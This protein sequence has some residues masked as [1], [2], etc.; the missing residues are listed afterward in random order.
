M[1]NVN[2]RRVARVALVFALVVLA[3]PTVARADWF[4]TPF[5]GANFGGATSKNDLGA[6]LGDSSALTYGVSGGFMGK[7][8]IGFEEDFG[9][10]KKFFAP[11]AGID[12]TNLL[13]LMSNV[14]V[15]IP[16]GGQSGFGVRPYVVGGV[17]L[18]RTNVD[19][20]INFVD[21][22]NNSFGFDVGGGVNIYFWHIGVRGDIRYFRD[23]S[24]ASAD[25][26]LG[27]ILGE[28]KLDFWRGT[29]GVVF[30]F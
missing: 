26:P 7:G 19:T 10:T 16:I 29:G 12:Q 18:M 27:F 23:F 3:L 6:A 1:T 24:D 14:I 4:I 25:N 22:A 9:Y 30:R 15:G 11:V 5:I 20:A 21:L 2:G 17:G 8:I 13:T 28:G